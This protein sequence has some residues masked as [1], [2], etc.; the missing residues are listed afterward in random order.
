MIFPGAVIGGYSAKGVT[1]DGTNDYLTHSGAPTGVADGK[2]GLAS[3]WIKVSTPGSD[4]YVLSNGGTR[5]RIRVLTSGLVI[6]VGLTTSV[7]TAV[8]MQSTASIATGAWKHILAAWDAASSANCKLYVNGS[9]ATDLYSRSDAN[10]DYNTGSDWSFCADWNGLNKVAADVADFWLD[11]A[12]WLDLTSSTN[13]EKFAKNGRP[14][15]LG[16]DGSKPTGTAP[17]IYF[18]GPASNWGTNAG[19]GGNFSLT[20]SLTDASTKPSY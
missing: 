18:K 4:V 1:F 13:R 3:F 16:Q 20:G 6:F 8:G 19:T 12:Q 5:F 11:T 15:Y 9:D 7:S 10:I 14:M 2:T 17:K